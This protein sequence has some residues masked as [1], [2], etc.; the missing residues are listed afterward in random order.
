MA[1]LHGERLRCG[2][3]VAHA[4]G[5]VNV[6]GHNVFDVD[7]LG[8]A[9]RVFELRAVD[10]GRCGDEDGVERG[11]FEQAAVIADER[12]LGGNGA[13]G[14]QTPGIDVGKTGNLDVG[15]SGCLT[16]EFEAAIS[17]ADDGNAKTAVGTKHA[18]RR[19]DCDGE[20]S[21]GFAYKSAA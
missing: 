7:M 8:R 20:S 17:R 16:R 19:G 10:V 1:H 21:G 11:V 13:S 9:G 2:S 3:R 15:G 4:L 12:G 6:E 18:L 5:I 14:I